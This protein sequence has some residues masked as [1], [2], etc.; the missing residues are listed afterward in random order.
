MRHLPK[1]LLIPCLL[2]AFASVA[3]ASNGHGTPDGQPP[4]DETVCNGFSG[5]AFGLCNAYCEAMDCDS[6]T[7]HASAAACANARAHF[8]QKTGSDVPCGTDLG[9]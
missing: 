5:A 8:M 6:P 1:L 4:A 7:P 3:P 9:S 2:L